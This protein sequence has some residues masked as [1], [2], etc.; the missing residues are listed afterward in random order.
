MYYNI[1]R[2]LENIKQE[3]KKK[4]DRLKFMYDSQKDILKYS[5]FS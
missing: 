3:Q 1:D 2:S 4:K 5:S